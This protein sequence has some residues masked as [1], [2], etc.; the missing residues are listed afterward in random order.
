MGLFVGKSKVEACPRYLRT[1]EMKLGR[2]NDADRL[3]RGGVCGV[4][5]ALAICRWGGG[6]LCLHLPWLCKHDA[7]KPVEVIRNVLTNPLELEARC[8]QL[9][10]R[11]RHDAYNP[12]EVKRA[13]LTTSL[14]I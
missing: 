2:Q 5:A 4:L 1:C 13:V 10:W 11:Y 12:I 6:G 9:H 14:A 8:S 3:G 7:Y